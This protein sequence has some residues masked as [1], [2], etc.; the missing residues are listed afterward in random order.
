MKFLVP[1]YSQKQSEAEIQ[2]DLYCS[3]KSVEGKFT[4]KM[5]I[6][7]KHSWENTSGPENGN[8]GENGLRYIRRS[9]K[10]KI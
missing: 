2:A 9:P 7:G 6:Q 10:K 4:S 3:I 5:S 8:V 1:I